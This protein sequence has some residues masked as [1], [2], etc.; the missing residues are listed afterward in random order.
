MAVINGVLQKVFSNGMKICTRTANGIT[1]TNVFDET[2][3]LLFE[4]SK[5]ITKSQVGNKNVLTKVRTVND[6]NR[7]YNF[8]SATSLRTDRVYDNTNNF[9]GLRQ[10]LYVN[11]WLDDITGW[12]KIKS[13]K[14][15]AN[16]NVRFNKNFDP[17]GD[18]SR[19]YDYVPTS[20]IS[21]PRAALHAGNSH[22]WGGYD[23][24]FYS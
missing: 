5:K 10:E 20:E 1:H 23:Y 7:I 8:A 21:N 6:P 12:H 19:R 4:T 24:N 11:N 2:G 16:S 18:I 9:M 14:Q 3:K 22:A 17:Y 15:Q 13:A